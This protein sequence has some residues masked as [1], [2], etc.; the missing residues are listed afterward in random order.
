MGPP[1]ISADQ[2]ARLHSERG[3][4]KAS[5]GPPTISADQPNMADDFEVMEQDASMGPP[6]I[7]ADQRHHFGTLLIPYLSFNGAADDLGGSAWPAVMR[8]A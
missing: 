8:L 3:F 2:Q 6:T 1:T 4:G 7:S 5:M